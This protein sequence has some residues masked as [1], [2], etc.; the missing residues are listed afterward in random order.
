MDT[1]KYVAEVSANENVANSLAALNEY[2]TTL[3]KESK[4]SKLVNA[5]KALEAAKVAYKK[6]SI[7]VVL[8]D[9]LYNELQTTTVRTAVSEFSHTHNLPN[10]FTWF[11][12][13]GKDEQVGIIDT[14]QK[15]GSHLKSL[16]DSYAAGNKVAR[17]KKTTLSELQAQMAELQAQMAELQNGGK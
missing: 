4:D 7:R 16:H 15:L 8:A 5:A 10:L 6:E 9:K 17:K 1:K 11:D 14:I 3:L 13:N 2:K 12:T